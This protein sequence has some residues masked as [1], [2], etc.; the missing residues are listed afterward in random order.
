MK[1]LKVITWARWKHYDPFAVR[2]EEDKRKRK[3]LTFESHYFTMFT[4]SVLF[5][6][7]EYPYPCLTMS[8]VAPKYR[9]LLRFVSLADMQAV[10]VIPAEYR[11]RLAEGFESAVKE[12]RRIRQRD[13]AMRKTSDMA[14]G[15]QLVRTDTGEV[16]MEIEDYLK[17]KQ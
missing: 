1:H 17:G 14:P 10:F 7:Y 15:S 13:A 12:S 6:T 9:V 8:V 3:N 4:A 16:V 2:P 11:E 5:P